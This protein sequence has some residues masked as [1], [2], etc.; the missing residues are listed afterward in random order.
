MAKAAALKLFALRGAVRRAIAPRP[1]LQQAPVAAP[2]PSG[3]APEPADRR[4]A[5]RRSSLQSGLVSDGVGFAL[6]CTILDISHAGARIHIEAPAAALPPA[7]FYLI[8]L[9]G[10]A[11]YEA[12]QI[13]TAAPEY[14]LSFVRK[15]DLSLRPPSA[16]SVEA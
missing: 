12:R 15:L 9:R 2:P 11:A 8:D 4:A 13:W 3:Q 14:G 16:S 7:P 1:T 10:K 6:R 5:A